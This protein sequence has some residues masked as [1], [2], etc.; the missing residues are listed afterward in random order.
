[1]SIIKKNEI[2]DFTKESALDYFIES[3][4]KNVAEI[5]KESSEDIIVD[6]IFDIG[7]SVVPG[8]GGIL[9]NI[10][11]KRETQNLKRLIYELSTRL[12]EIKNQFDNMDLIS[13]NKSEEAFEQ[14]VEYASEEK[15]QDKITYMVNGFVNILDLGEAVTNEFVITYYDVLK[16]LRIVDITIL[17]YMF[18][19][20]YRRITTYGTL[21]D[22]LKQLDISFDQY[23]SIRVNLERLGLLNKKIEANIL[24]DLDNITDQF[25]LI[26]KYFD[27]IKNE[28]D[29]KRLKKLKSFKYKSSDSYE[30]SKF[31][32]EFVR[33][34]I[35]KKSD[36]K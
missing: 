33:F 8:A 22:I 5:G 10:R 17:K 25:E 35:E 34:F 3:A 16:S 12:D 11:L 1:M 4:V 23:K 20:K 27:A 15:Q 9:Q 21:D 30:I 36:E 29:L 26:H 13:Q 14:I 32:V 24:D 7:A 2:K 18:N 31:G 28:K 6:S 19:I